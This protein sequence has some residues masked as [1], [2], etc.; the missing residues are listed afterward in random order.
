MTCDFIADQLECRKGQRHQHRPVAD[1]R[2]RDS[3]R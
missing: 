1:L 3:R 2:P